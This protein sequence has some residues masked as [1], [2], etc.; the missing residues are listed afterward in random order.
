MSEP[1]VKHLKMD[2]KQD[3]KTENPDSSEVK[4]KIEKTDIK[5]KKECFPEPEHTEFSEWFRSI[6]PDIVKIE[7]QHEIEKLAAQY[8]QKNA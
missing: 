2:Q 7:Q 3:I 1:K 8:L 6:E 4:I 5:N